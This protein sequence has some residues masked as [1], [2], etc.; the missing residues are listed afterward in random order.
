MKSKQ[1]ASLVWRF[2]RPIIGWC[3][4]LLGVL[5]LLLPVL[6]GGIFLALGVLLV[7]RRNRLIRWVA[8][9]I[10]LL[11]R[12]WASHTQPLVRIVGKVMLAGQQQMS[13]QRRRLMWWY[14][15]RKKAGNPTTA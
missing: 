15:E 1:I 8:V 14:M 13:R 2:M 6:Q 10:K 12:Q 7:G 4:I 3:C 5:G 9:H 11:L